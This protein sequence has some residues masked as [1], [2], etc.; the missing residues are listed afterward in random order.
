[1]TSC[2]GEEECSIR[3]LILEFDG[4]SLE[5][6]PE[7][8]R[9]NLPPSGGLCDVCKLVLAFGGL[10]LEHVGQRRVPGAGGGRRRSC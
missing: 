2:G 1:M 5:D 4:L 3:A 6:M 8:R 9:R 10:S 7:G